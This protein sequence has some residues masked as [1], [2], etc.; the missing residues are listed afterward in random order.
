[1]TRFP[2]DLENDSGLLRSLSP[3]FSYFID[4]DKE[5]NQFII[6]DTLTNHEIYRIPLYL[7]NPS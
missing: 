3:S 6:R 1:M 5:V 2:E 7:M 4:L